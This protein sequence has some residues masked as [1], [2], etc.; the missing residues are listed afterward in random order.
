MFKKDYFP[1][2]LKAKAENAASKED[3]EKI[4]TIVENVK[5]N[6]KIQFDEIQKKNELF[7]DEIKQ[8]KNRFNSKQFELY[9]DL[10][11][12][13][14]DLKLSADEL[15]DAATKTKLHDFSKK[16][17]SASVSVEKSAI[18]IDDRHYIKLRDILAEFEG[19]KFGKSELILKRLRNKTKT[20]LENIEFYNS[21]EENIQQ[22]GRI[23]DNYDNLLDE[24]KK[25]F[26][27]KVRG[28]D[29]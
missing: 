21:I 16:V 2:Y 12:S 18:L 10:W 17:H 24:L 1:S 7:F 13:L 28:E 15:W 5:Q 9:N 27:I 29:I 8:S 25:Q 19:F 23:K 11:S 3:I 4:T 6:N 22:N 14:I 26:K 20:Q